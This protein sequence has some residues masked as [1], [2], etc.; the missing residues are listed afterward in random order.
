LLIKSIVYCIHRICKIP[1]P[2]DEEIKNL[3]I[4]HFPLVFTDEYYELSY[5]EFEEWVAKNDEVH[6]FL[7]EFF[8]LQTRYNAMKAYIKYLSEFEFIYDSHKL[9]ETKNT[10]KGLMRKNSLLEKSS[11]SLF[12]REVVNSTEFTEVIN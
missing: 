12:S 5:E 6:S 11:F 2:S 1:L 3:L 8:D 4:K 9:N 10:K 7:M